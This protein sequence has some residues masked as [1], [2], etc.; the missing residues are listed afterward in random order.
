[1]KQAEL[2]HPRVFDDPEWSDG[3]YRRNAKNITRVGKRFAKLL[4]ESGFFTGKILDVGCGFGAVPI[5]FAKSMPY[6]HITGIDLGQSILDIGKAL[7]DK[8]ALKDQID[9]KKGDAMDIPFEDNY[10]DVVSNTFLLHIVDDPVKML[11]EI[12][13]VAKPD[14]KIMITDLSRGFLAL[15]VGKFR[16]AYKLKEALKIIKKSGLREGRTATGPFWWDYMVGV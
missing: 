1:M 2:F 11:N 4:N 10:F 14:A 12:E 16:T 3:Y 6:A 8:A 15:F 7:V 13:R 9:L 5:E